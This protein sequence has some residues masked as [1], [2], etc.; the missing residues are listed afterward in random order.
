MAFAHD[1]FLWMKQWEQ[2]SSNRVKMRLK[3]QWLPMT[4]SLHMVHFVI[5]N[6]MKCFRHVILR[7][8][9]LLEQLRNTRHRHHLRGRLPSISEYMK[10]GQCRAAEP[11]G[12]ALSISNIFKSWRFKL[13]TQ[14]WELNA[15]GLWRH[16]Q[17]PRGRNSMRG[18]GYKI[19]NIFKSWRLA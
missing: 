15:S 16:Q 3:D 11:I 12:S 2:S 14:R 17:T 1:H 5:P 9:L 13:V 19:T 7:A 18:L 4:T 6:E 8:S 10:I